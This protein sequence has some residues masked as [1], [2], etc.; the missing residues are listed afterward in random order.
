MNIS[1][2]AVEFVSPELQM[3][4]DV[5]FAAVKKNG[6]AIDKLPDPLK[7]NERIVLAGYLEHPDTLNFAS[8]RQR[9]YMKGLLQALGT[10]DLSPY[11]TDDY[12]LDHEK[13]NADINKHND[14]Q[15]IELFDRDLFNEL[16]THVHLD[17][18]PSNLLRQTPFVFRDEA[19]K[20][21]AFSLDHLLPFD[22]TFIETDPAVFCPQFSRDLHEKNITT[23]THSALYN[24]Q[25]TQT[26]KASNTLD[27][28]YTCKTPTVLLIESDQLH[29]GHNDLLQD[30][31]WLG[32]KISNQVKI[33]VL[34]CYSDLTPD[35]QNRIESTYMD[36][37]SIQSNKTMPHKH[38]TPPHE[39]DFKQLDYLTSEEALETEL[40]TLESYL[41]DTPH[42]HVRI[43]LQ[44]SYEYDTLLAHDFKGDL[45]L[46]YLPIHIRDAAFKTHKE[47]EDD[48]IIYQ[49][50]SSFEEQIE[51][52]VQRAQLSSDDV[53]SLAKHFSDKVVRIPDK[54]KLDIV[55]NIKK[56]DG[57][58]HLK[59]NNRWLPV[60]DLQLLDPHTSEA[61]K[62]APIPDIQPFLDDIYFHSQHLFMNNDIA[63]SIFNALLD[64]V[65]N[66]SQ[67]IIFEGVPALGK[68]A[69]TKQFLAALTESTHGIYVQ[70]IT[71]AQD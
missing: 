27:T 23:L 69:Y 1:G 28:L 50:A 15:K 14:L 62:T 13:I 16:L 48:I 67:W 5:A 51:H 2:Y 53:D 32:K 70:D 18:I 34:G 25:D 4:E 71:S 7:D 12:T 29:S 47:T 37:Y 52:V 61:S 55:A 11:I 30:R 68:D 60:R 56:H 19:L 57:K 38:P 8:P 3:D 21:E 66:D 44:N 41:Q 26:H 59:A 17:A 36:E 64:F 54:P 39:Q 31:R 20:N 45:L 6:V 22:L 40:A 9:N 58:W 24:R 10:P 35:V 43:A 49:Y 65:N 46:Q 63:R 42:D 33:V